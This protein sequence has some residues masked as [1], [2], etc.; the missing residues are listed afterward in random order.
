MTK[1]ICPCCE[2]HFDTEENIKPPFKKG[3]RVEFIKSKLRKGSL[4]HTSDAFNWTGKVVSQE[5]VRAGKHIC[6]DMK[7]KDVW[8]ITVAY[9]PHGRGGG[10][11]LVE[12]RFFQTEIRSL[13]PTLK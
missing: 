9:L 12:S 6:K 13:K 7:N 10:H 11:H 3:Q 4:G 2:F 5:L 8:L 1:I